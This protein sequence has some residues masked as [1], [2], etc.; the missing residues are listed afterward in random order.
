M[1]TTTAMGGNSARVG[2]GRFLSVL[3]TDRPTE[4]YETYDEPFILQCAIIPLT[5]PSIPSLSDC[6]EGRLW[7]C[8]SVCVSWRTHSL[9]RTNEGTEER[10]KRKKVSAR[11]ME[12]AARPSISLKCSLSRVSTVSQQLAES[13]LLHFRQSFILEAAFNVYLLTWRSEY[14][15]WHSICPFCHRVAKLSLS[16]LGVVRALHTRNIVTT[17]RP[18]EPRCCV[19]VCVCVR[20]WIFVFLLLKILSSTSFH[21]CTGVLMR[22][23]SDMF[24]FAAPCPFGLRAHCTLPPFHLTVT[25]SY[26]TAQCTTIYRF[27]RDLKTGMH[28]HKYMASNSFQTLNSYS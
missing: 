27:L 10:K 25:Y 2:G 9:T 24:L 14:A 23:S 17:K 1:A 13:A 4:S 22:L 11:G 16:F 20:V 15:V 3:A 5:L 6:C 21:L 28:T 26:N 8:V 7:V 19:C 12:Q 18:Q